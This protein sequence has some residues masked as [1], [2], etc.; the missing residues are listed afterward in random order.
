MRSWPDWQWQYSR[1]MRSR[2]SCRGKIPPRCVP[3][4]QSGQVLRSMHPESG[5]GRENRQFA[6]RFARH[7]SEN[8]LALARYARHASEMP[9]KSPLEDTPREDLARKGRFS[10]HGPLESCTARRSCHPA[11]TKRPSARNP[12]AA[13]QRQTALAPAIPAPPSWQ[14]ATHSIRGASGSHTANAPTPHRPAT[15]RRQADVKS[16][17]ARAPQRQSA[18]RGQPRRKRSR[19]PHQRQ[20]P[21]LQWRASA[22]CRSKAQRES[23]TTANPG[24]CPQRQTARA[25]HARISSSLRRDFALFH[26]KRAPTIHIYPPLL[27]RGFPA[28]A[29]RTAAFPCHPG[30]CRSAPCAC[31]GVPDRNR[32]SLAPRQCGKHGNP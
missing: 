4:R 7:A 24:G 31:H 18:T 30:E 9:R 3:G 19:T 11:S 5:L 22:R 12:C 28:D 16:C 29:P 15:L 21:A 26:R 1:A 13:D 14:R 27:W 2:G 32:L 6:A 10:L 23:L 17:A 8:G 25:P 20:R